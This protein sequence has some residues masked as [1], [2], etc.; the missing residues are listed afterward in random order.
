[1]AVS[2]GLAFQIQY[3]SS[4]VKRLSASEKLGGVQEI[5]FSK[6]GVLTENKNLKVDC[7][8]TE[9]KLV[10]NNQKNKL[11][12]EEMVMARPLIIENILFNCTDARVEMDSSAKFKPEGNPTDCCL[13]EFL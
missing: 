11:I 1:M 9:G 12:A 4:L 6:S 8:F 7:F 5:L 2:L 13:L 10:Q 3:N